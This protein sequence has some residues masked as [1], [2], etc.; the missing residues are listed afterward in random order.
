MARQ[1]LD[2]TAPTGRLHQLA[3]R[4]R[5][6]VTAGETGKLRAWADGR[7]ITHEGRCGNRLIATGTSRVETPA[8]R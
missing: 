8:S 5:G 6:V 2:W 1:V 4:Y 3:L 7:D